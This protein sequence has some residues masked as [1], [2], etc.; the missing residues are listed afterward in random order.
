[1]DS[2]ARELSRIGIP[3]YRPGDRCAGSGSHGMATAGRYVEDAEPESTICLSCGQRVA[4]V[5]RAPGRVSEHYRKV[6]A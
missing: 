3:G 1:M 5:G 2:G 6:E 4:L